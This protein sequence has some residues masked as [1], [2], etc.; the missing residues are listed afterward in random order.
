MNYFCLDCYNKRLIEKGKKPLG[1]KDVYR[2][3]TF[4][5]DEDCEEWLRCVIAVKSK[6][7]F[8]FLKYHFLVTKWKIKVERARRKRESHK[9]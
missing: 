2:D 6:N 7:P 5:D 8:G 4:C 1:E 3:W 9:F